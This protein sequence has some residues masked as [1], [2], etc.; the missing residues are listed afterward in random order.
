VLVRGL[1]AVALVATAACWC[2]LPA[3]AT[4]DAFVV[5]ETIH[6]HARPI[7]PVLGLDLC[8]AA[9]RAKASALGIDLI[10]DE[11]CAP[12]PDNLTVLPIAKRTAGGPGLVGWTFP[13]EPENNGWTPASL[14]RTFP[15]R[16]SSPDGLLSFITT[17]GGFV[18]APYR[19]RSTPLSEYAAF[20]HL[21]DVA[22]FD[23]YPLNHCQQDLS[24]VYDAQ[25]RFIK[26]TGPMP[27]FQWIETGPLRPTY[28]GGF[29]MT[30]AQLSAEV[31]LAITGGARAIG[32]FTATWTPDE[33]AFD[34]TPSI[35]HQIARTTSLIAALQPGLTGAAMLASANSPAIKIAARR[36]A[37]GKLYVFAVNAS[38]NVV[39]VQAYVPSLDA[40]SMRVFGEKRSLAVGNHR[41]VDTF[42]KYAVHVYVAG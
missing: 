4:A 28:C 39:K 15:Y 41:F 18:P 19:S 3:G 35:A 7:F 17:G 6:V 24:A 23:L 25:Q 36:G 33:H 31:W 2:A 12:S 30:P 26:L 38:T 10:I 11:S 37:D 1:A 29:A 40:S 32:F 14:A 16:R 21:A 34:V 20:A 42:T 9:D 27:T 8:A 13:D 22:G 5:R